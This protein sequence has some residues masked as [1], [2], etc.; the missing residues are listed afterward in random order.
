MMYCS[1]PYWDILP[2]DKKIDKFVKSI[3]NTILE[4]IFNNSSC[5]TFCKDFV[6]ICYENAS[7]LIL[8][9]SSWLKLVYFLTKIEIWFVKYLFPIDGDNLYSLLEGG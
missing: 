5:S 6:N 8:E 2:R 4:K 9:D 7:F 1:T 3:Q